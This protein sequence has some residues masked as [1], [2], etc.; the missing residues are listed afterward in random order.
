MNAN[1]SRKKSVILLTISTTW[2]K[3]FGFLREMITA[4]YFG[5]GVVKDAFSVSQAIPSR[6]GSSVYSA[7]NSSL[8]PY[9]IHLKEEE[10]E[11]A[12][13]HAY[14]SV[15][16]WL[17]AILIGF[18]CALLLFPSA[19]VAVM[20]PGFYKDPQRLGLTIYLIRFTAVVFLLQVLSSM[21]VTLMQIFNN[22]LPQIVIQFTS[23]PAGVLVL[24]VAGLAHRA[25]PTA[26]AISALASGIVMF[27]VAYFYA[28][29][30]KGRF[31]TAK[32]WDAHVVGFVKFLTPVLTG[33][34][35]VISYTLV[36]QLMASYLPVG[37]ISA[38]NYSSLLYNLPVTLFAV[39]IVNVMYPSLSS[40]S[41]QND[42]ERLRHSFMNGFRMIWA[43]VLPAASG[44]AILSFPI[45][46]LVY[47]RGAFDLSAAQLVAR[48][49]LFYSLGVPFLALQVLLGVAF[50]SE[51]DNVTPL[52]ARIVGL[53]LNGTLNYLFGF[54]FKMYAPGFALGTAVTW[55]VIFLLMEWKW[56]VRHQI[57]LIEILRDSYRPFL[58][59]LVMAVA[60]TVWMHFIPY[61]GLWLILAIVFGATTYGLSLL[62]LK[63]PTAMYFLDTVAQRL[64]GR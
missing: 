13:W 40:A 59:V 62:I 33:E 19:F 8:L 46:A 29:P 35:M 63:E 18:V 56:S 49:L 61:Q 38:L 28:F 36:D 12:F 15:Y 41:A 44:L 47:M 58:G 50:L 6:L 2:S 3:L 7:V 14:S 5:A 48:T 43:I 24:A 1:L 45:V 16:R 37:N 27:S 25:T 52:R 54:V 39:P 30:L 26:L 22:F 53:F 20:A 9:L 60:L 55:A 21:Q 10:G 4:Y 23:S 64:L 11:D 31:G 42:L 51:K 34:L 17:L 32:I 57:K